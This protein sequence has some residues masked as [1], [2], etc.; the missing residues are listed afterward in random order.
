MIN[1][2]HAFA[3]LGIGLVITMTIAFVDESNYSFRFLTSI[4][5]V[6][7]LLF[8]TGILSVLPILFYAVSLATKRK[9]QA[10]YFA[11]F[12]FSPGLIIIALNLIY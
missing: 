11:L 6:F 5:E 8:F 10:F 9:R 12:G 7:N 4:N 1:K 3:I 2:T